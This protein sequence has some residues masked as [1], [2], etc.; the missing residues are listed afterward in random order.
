VAWITWAPQVQGFAQNC[1]ATGVT[2][3]KCADNERGLCRHN[4]TG[5]TPHPR[6]A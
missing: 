3:Q 5:Q 4:E 1:N 2:K 6:V